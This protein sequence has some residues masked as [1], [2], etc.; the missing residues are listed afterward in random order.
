MKAI[1]VNQKYE[2]IPE[3]LGEIPVFGYVQPWSE[4]HPECNLK[5]KTKWKYFPC[6]TANIKVK[7]VYKDIEV[8]SN[9][10]IEISCN[11]AR[12]SAETGG[13]PFGAVIIQVDDETNNVIRYWK[14]HNH[15]NEWNDPT[16]HAEISVIR[17]AC[18]ELGVYDLGTIHKDRTKLQQKGSVSHCELYSSCEPCPMCMGAIY[19]AHI[20]VLVFAATR[21][22]ASQQG[23]NFIDEELYNEFRKPYNEKK[24]NIY[25]STC[26]NSLDAFNLWKRTE[27]THY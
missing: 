1:E 6:Q 24:I 5:D 22:D 20:P 8:K 25:Q 19:W 18:E 16:A 7:G 23:L 11:E 10:W 13:G 17:I 15:V 14:E 3:P 26:A 2:G 12:I 4:Y 9:K 27:K 21:F